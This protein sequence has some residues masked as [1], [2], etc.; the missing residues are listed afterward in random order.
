MSHAAVN[1]TGDEDA[2]KTDSTEIVT[3]L[4]KNA[5]SEIRVAIRWWKNHPQL[6]LRVWSDGNR[7]GKRKPTKQGL[8]LKLE[9]VPELQAALKLALDRMPLAT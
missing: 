9:R 6:D 8:S 4:R 3:V 1:Q 2:P 7:I 5:V